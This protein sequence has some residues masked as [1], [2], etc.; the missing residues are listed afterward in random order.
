MNKKYL[1]FVTALPGWLSRTEGSFLEHAAKNTKHLPGV[2]VELG[3]FQGK[4][5]IWLAQAKKPVYA[6]DPHK[7]YVE[8]NLRFP[9]TF[10]RFKKNI[11]KAR[12]SKNIKPIRK[13]SIEAAKDWKLPIRVLFIDALHDEK[14]ALR[15]FRTWSKFVVEGGIVAVHD[16]FLHWCGSEKVAL[17]H[18]INSPQFKDIG[19]KG[20]ILYGTKT[21]EER[22][23]KDRIM[24]VIINFAI[25]T[26]RVRLLLFLFSG[27]VWEFSKKAVQSDRTFSSK[28]IT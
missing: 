2:V 26:N 18:I 10:K 6:I 21:N 19:F 1:Q 14:N 20:S 13:S 4:S 15:D 5:T 8:K 9:E 7:G 27:K 16:S 22:S 28:I 3:S 23:I 12:V 24:Q 25:Y 17:E 11:Q